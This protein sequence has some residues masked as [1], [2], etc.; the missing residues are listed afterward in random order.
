MTNEKLKICD[1]LW[2]NGFKCELNH[3][4]NWNLGKQLTYA[5]AQN[6]PFAI[7]FGEDEIKNEVVKLKNLTDAKQ[8]IVVPLKDLVT[9]L[10]QKINEI[11]EGFKKESN[12]E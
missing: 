7:V 9:V 12:E 2:R 8:E 5:N 4:L 6:I 1:L 10:R 3:K 11:P